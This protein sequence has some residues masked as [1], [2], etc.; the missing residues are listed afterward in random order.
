M[1]EANNSYLSFKVG[2]DT[3]AVH[4]SKVNEIREYE[5]PRKVPGS[6]SFMKGVIDHREE[7][8]PVIDTGI[9]FGL[10]PV[11]ITLQTC[12]IVIDVLKKDTNSIF[13]VGI[14]TDAVTDVFES[15][16][17]NL[18]KIERDYTPNYIQAT[19]KLDDNFYLILNSDE[20]FSLNE[21]IGMS[22]AIQE[23]K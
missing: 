2:T 1:E 18:K 16:D 21:I 22:E 14:L 12:I 20:V 10:N 19:Y 11:E 23:I 4:V 17:S 6:V 8:V 5:K 15:E 3:F 9:K 7:V 13:K